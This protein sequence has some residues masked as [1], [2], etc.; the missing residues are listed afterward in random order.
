LTIRTEDGDT[1][2]RT[3]GDRPTTDEPVVL[4][5][6]VFELFRWR[7]GRRSRAQMAAMDWSGDPAPFLDHLAVFGPS[8]LDIVE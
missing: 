6:S 2:A 7:M 4:T 8:P 3:T 1:Q 5:T